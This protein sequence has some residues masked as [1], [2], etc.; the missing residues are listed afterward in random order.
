MQTLP[1]MKSI[2]LAGCAFLTRSIM[3][4]AQGIEVAPSEL[5][6]GEIEEGGSQMMPCTL[7]GTEPIPHR[8]EHIELSED[9]F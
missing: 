7:E 3:A 1:I 2:L 6:S 9:G 4:A 8:L 5:D